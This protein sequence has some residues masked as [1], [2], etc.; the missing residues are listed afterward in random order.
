MDGDEG[1]HRPS[2]ESGGDAS[3]AQTVSYLEATEDPSKPVMTLM[4]SVD[5]TLYSSLV[6]F[7]VRSK[8]G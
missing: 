6:F 1:G 7:R 8:T 3:A 4:E 5:P 2:F